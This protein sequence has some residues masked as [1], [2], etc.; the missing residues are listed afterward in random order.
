MEDV[1]NLVTLL[2]QTEKFGT[3][4]SQALRVHSD[5]MRTKRYQRAEEMAQKIPIKMIFPL[6]LFI[7]PM[8]LLIIM[9][10]GMFIIM[11]YFGKN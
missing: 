10:P 8:F 11:K 5:A 3:S 9:G 6:V 7:F 2:V 1:S 4:I